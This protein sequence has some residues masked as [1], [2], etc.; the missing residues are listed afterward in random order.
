MKS[1]NIDVLTLVSVLF[2]T[3]DITREEL[4][5]AINTKVG[6]NTP[7]GKARDN[8]GFVTL[9]V[10][11]DKDTGQIHRSRD[12]K[13][14]QINFRG[15]SRDFKNQ[16]A[17]TPGTLL[18]QGQVGGVQLTPELIQVLTALTQQQ[19]QPAPQPQQAQQPTVRTPPRQE[20][21]GNQQEFIDLELTDIPF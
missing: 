14:I 17:Q 18:P 3:G 1:F 20:N 19:K 6:T 21:N 15:D 16:Q 12:E 2:Q 4:K 10:S 13:R 11:T 8:G 5:T 7:V 9:F